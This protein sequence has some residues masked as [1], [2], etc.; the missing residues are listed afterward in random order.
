[1]SKA[2]EHPERRALSVSEAARAIGVSRAT[3]YRLVQQKRLATAKIG[4]RTLIPIS[5]IDTLL[6]RAMTK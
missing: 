1:M 4:S 5:E 3:L 6:A 2:N